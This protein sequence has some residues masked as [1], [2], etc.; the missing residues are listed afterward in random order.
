MYSRIVNQIHCKSSS[1]DEALSVFEQQV[2]EQPVLVCYAGGRWG[3]ASQLP[4]RR[5]I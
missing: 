5:L 3:A 4:E 2:V 1:P